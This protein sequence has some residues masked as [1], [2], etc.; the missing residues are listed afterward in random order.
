MDGVL[1]SLTEQ[2]V[3]KTLDY[4]EE[5]RSIGFDTIF[6]SLQM[7]E[8]D[9]A[10]LLSPLERIGGFARERGMTLMAD[11]SPRA[12]KHFS[13]GKLREAGVT[14]LRIDYGLDNA[15]IAALSR[16]WTVA[17][18]A[19]TIGDDFLDDLRRLD[20]NFDALE[21]WHNYYPRPETGLDEEDFRKRNRWLRERGLKVAAFVA[22]DGNLRGPLREGL[23]TLERHRGMS[24]F[25]AALELK[26]ENEADRV[27]VADLSV[28]E[29]TR[30]RFEALNEGRVLL[31]A[32]DWLDS[33]LW[34]DTHRNR[35]DIARDAIR[36]E[37]ARRRAREPIEPRRCIQ[38][39][40]GAITV[41]NDLYARY[42][43][44]FQIVL[45]PLPAD[46][47]VNVLGY[48]A[49]RDLPLLRFLQRSGHP[50]AFELGR[51]AGGTGEPRE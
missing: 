44:E 40:R 42:A 16:E 35:P 31:E 25:A 47:R 30:R 11:V 45:N 2:S 7:P 34:A 26:H 46:E 6:T 33:P 39:P 38:R 41:D 27:I 28:S 13:A 20:A 24:P 12:F 10:G 1:V 8:E 22:G 17:F 29:R 23:P 50:F 18:N 4:L 36:S 43:G 48:V 9:P 3:E 21:A 19:S 51:P 32:E 14:G 49:E 5:M 15:Q 37:E